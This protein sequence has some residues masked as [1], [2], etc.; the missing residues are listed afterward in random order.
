M[1]ALSGYVARAEATVIEVTTTEQK[2]SSADGCSLQEAI[3]AANIKDNQ[4]V[5]VDVSNTLDFID[6]EC[7][8][9]DD[10]KASYNFV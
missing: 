10:G 4:A 8:L 1:I 9:E 6:T 3:W 7:V 2:V 5:V